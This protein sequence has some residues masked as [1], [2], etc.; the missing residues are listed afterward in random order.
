MDYRNEPAPNGLNADIYAY[1]LTTKQ[2]FVVSASPDTQNDPSISGNTIVWSDF[3]KGTEAD[4]YGYDLSTRKEFV[5]S[6]RAW[7]PG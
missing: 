5:V 2:E 6:S 7:Q 4:I 3:R 1:D